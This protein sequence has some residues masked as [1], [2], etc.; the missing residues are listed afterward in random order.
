MQTIFLVLKQFKQRVFLLVIIPLFTIGFAAIY[1]LYTLNQAHNKQ[2]SLEFTKEL[3]QNV[4]N[5]QIKIKNTYTFLINKQIPFKACQKKDSLEEIWQSIK[6][7]HPSLLSLHCYDS[8]AKPLNSVGS[9]GLAAT[10]KD[11]DTLPP[12]LFCPCKKRCSYSH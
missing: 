11:V 6:K 3:R 12:P 9:V 2:T 7:S 10:P 4:S 8:H 5:A 1:Y